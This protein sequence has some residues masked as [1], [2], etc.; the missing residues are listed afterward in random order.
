MYMYRFSNK[1]IDIN[2]LHLD[3][4]KIKLVEADRLSSGH[5]NHVI[6]NF[7]SYQFRNRM[8]FLSP[9]VVLTL[10]K[11]RVKVNKFSKHYVFN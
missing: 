10:I 4:S 9:K 1:F 11:Y 6:P 3:F 7:I 8:Q 2:Y 5:N